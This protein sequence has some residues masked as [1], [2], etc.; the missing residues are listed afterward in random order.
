M[1]KVNKKHVGS[2]LD[3]LLAEDGLLDEASA[4]ALKRVLAWEVAEQM[5]RQKL[6]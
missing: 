5:K 1:G 2:D 3:S 4:V 6:S